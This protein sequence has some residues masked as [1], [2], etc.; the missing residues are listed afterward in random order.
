MSKPF[1]VVLI[2]LA[3]LLGLGLVAVAIVLA[4][5]DTERLKPLLIDR[6]QQ[7]WQ[8]TLAIPGQVRLSVFPKIGVELGEVSLSERNSATTFASARSAQASLALWP[9]LRGQVVVDRVLVEGLR[10][11]LVRG[12]DGRLNTDDLTGGAAPATPAA[13]S[14]STPVRFD[15]AGLS[16][17]DAAVTVDDRGARRK[18]IMSGLELETGR[19][20]PGAAGDLRLQGQLKS[21]PAAVDLAI[22]LDARLTIDTVQRRHKLDDIALKVDGRLAGQPG[23]SLSLGGALLAD[24]QAE[25]IGLSGLKLQASWPR[26][27]GGPLQLQASGEATALLD[28]QTLDARL[29]GTIDQS[30]FEARIGMPRFAPAAYTFDLKVDRLDLDRV[31]AGGGEASPAGTAAEETPIDLSALRTLDAKGQLRIG[32]VQVAK[33]QATELRAELR[34]AGGRLEIAPIAASLYQGRL[35][36]AMTIDARATPRLGLRQTLTGVQLGPMLKDALGRDS[37]EGRGDVTLNVAA[38]GATV[39]ALTRALGGDARI[40]LRDGAVRGINVAQVIRSAKARLG[41]GS[42][43]Q[44]GEGSRTEKTDFSE[45]TASF[46]IDR[47]V[48]RNRDLLAK[49]PL[50]RITGEGDVD[51]AAQRLDYLVKATVVTSLK[52]QGGPE[53]ESLSG[54][55]VPVRLNGPFDAIG[56]RIDFE[57]MAK[58]AVKQ[59]IESRKD[60]AKEKLRETLGDALKGLFGK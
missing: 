13:P 54:Q 43:E 53:L 16:V 49:S 32:A 20:A 28:K 41:G 27:A 56:W 38:Q 7:D 14:E 2:V 42:G 46:Q 50:L 47:G 59:K 25:R 19:L 34:A 15:V 24:L 11:T 18:L 5:F 3:S 40:A 12:V 60:E 10:A 33:M 26:A 30:R 31:L 39:S 1:R 17:R 37:L 57:A 58:E 23:A 4:T 45:L 52:G 22:A 36:G 6:V 21:E 8:R 29:A 44:T 51:L 35:A 9:L 48:A 55:T